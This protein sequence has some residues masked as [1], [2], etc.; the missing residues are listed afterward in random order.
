[1]QINEALTALANGVNPETGEILPANSVA[2]T[3]EAIRLLFTLAQELA[4]Q[5]ARKKTT[6]PKMSLEERKQKNIADGKP[7]KSNLPWSEGELEQLVAYYLE[8]GDI[9][10]VAAQMERSPLAIAVQ[11]G[12]AG[13]ISLEAVEQF[14]IK[15]EAQPAE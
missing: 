10:T 11:L 15:P 14:R 1:M 9:K 4:S 6:K 7:A 5:P 2:H 12:K 8:S 3:P 13:V